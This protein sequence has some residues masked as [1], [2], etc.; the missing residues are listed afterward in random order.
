MGGVHFPFL[1]KSQVFHREGVDDKSG[2]GLLED[3]EV[4][5]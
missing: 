4:T 2:R 1:G 3:S 5:I